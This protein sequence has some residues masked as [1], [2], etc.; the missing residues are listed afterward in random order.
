MIFSMPSRA[1]HQWAITVWTLSPGFSI[2]GALFLETSAEAPIKP[3]D[4]L[5]QIYQVWHDRAACSRGGRWILLGT[6]GSALV[7]PSGQSGIGAEFLEKACY[8]MATLPA[9]SRG[10]QRAAR[11]ACRPV[12]RSFRL[13]DGA[14]AKAPID[15]YET[16]AGTVGGG[17]RVAGYNPDTSLNGLQLEVTMEDP[18]VFITP[19]T[20]RVTYR[21]L[22]SGW[23]EVVCADNPMEHYKGEW[24]GLPKADVRIS[25]RR[26]GTRTYWIARGRKRTTALPNAD[27]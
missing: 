5:G 2:A 4:S 18:K 8:V 11:R 17:G 26:N 23:Q 1:A 10:I 13:I 14:L 6:I 21:P 19:L 16:S 20:A 12:R 3:T 9:A 15:K 7:Q 27:G 22:I 25:D 24:I